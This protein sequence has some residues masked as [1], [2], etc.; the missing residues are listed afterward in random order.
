MRLRCGCVKL[1]FSCTHAVASA[2]VLRLCVLLGCAG[3]LTLSVCVIRYMYAEG[4]KLVK[5]YEEEE[6]ELAEKLKVSG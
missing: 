4:M 6:A 2:P 1:V 5:R 3:A